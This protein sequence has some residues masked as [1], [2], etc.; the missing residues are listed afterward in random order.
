[1]GWFS[2]KEGEKNIP[3]PPKTFPSFK[4]EFPKY[5]SE[6]SPKELDD[7]KKTITEDMPPLKRPPMMQQYTPPKPVQRAPLSSYEPSYPRQTYQ[8]PTYQPSLGT[9]PEPISEKETPIKQG[10]SLFIKVDQYEEAL[11][12]LEL[13]TNSIRNAEDT[14]Q[15]IEELRNQEAQE[16]GVWKQKLDEI[17]NQLRM[18]DKTL[19]GR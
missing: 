6:F 18:M 19:F 4:S 8:Q 15:K 13:V 7:I 11:Q 14:L 16:L 17:K 1:M 3:Q 12:K 5:E 10:K 9:L 2:K